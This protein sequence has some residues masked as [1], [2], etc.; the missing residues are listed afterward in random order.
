[1]Q[2][3]FIEDCPVLV[4]HKRFSFVSVHEKPAIQKRR[5]MKTVF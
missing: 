5:L 4:Q 1:M 2:I 3:D